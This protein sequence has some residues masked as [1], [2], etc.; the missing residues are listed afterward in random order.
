[1]SNPRFPHKCTITRHSGDVQLGSD[2][3]TLLYKGSCRK[4]LD[5]FN[6]RHYNNASDTSQWV[7][8]LPVEVAVSFGDTLRAN[9]GVA[10]MEGVVCEWSVTNIEHENA[11]G[12]YSEDGDGVVT[13]L[14]GTATRGMHIYVNVNKN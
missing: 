5:K 3:D 12:V 13:S 14:D 6:N 8:S 11:D 9:D 10:E 4:E 1:M 2:T 7:V